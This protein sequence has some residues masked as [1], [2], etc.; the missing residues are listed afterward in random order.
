MLHTIILENCYLLEGILLEDSC[1]LG[2][3]GNT[4]TLINLPHTPVN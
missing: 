1:Y 2:L 4:E 3:W